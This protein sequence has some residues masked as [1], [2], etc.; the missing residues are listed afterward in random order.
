MQVEIYCFFHKYA[1]YDFARNIAHQ[2][3][4]VRSCEKLDKLQVQIR[5]NNICCFGS[6]P[7]HYCTPGP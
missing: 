3:S 2:T 5:K 7:S 1:P 6:L 4:I